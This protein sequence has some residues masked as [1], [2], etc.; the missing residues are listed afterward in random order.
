MLQVNWASL[1]TFDFN[2]VQP[3]PKDQRLWFVECVGADTKAPTPEVGVC[4]VEGPSTHSRLTLRI[5]LTEDQTSV[6]KQIKR[7]AVVMD[8]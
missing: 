6:S 1:M 3:A 8:T 4:L 5:C 2:V 7:L